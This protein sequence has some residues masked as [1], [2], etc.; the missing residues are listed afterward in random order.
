ME[1]WQRQ[2]QAVDAPA[3]AIDA[4][5]D[6]LQSVAE[7]R[8]A[9]LARRARGQPVLQGRQVEYRRVEFD[10]G[11]VELR[12][13]AAHSGTRH[14]DIYTPGAQ[15]RRGRTRVACAPV[16]DDQHPGAAHAV[17]AAAGGGGLQAEGVAE[18][19]E[20]E[21]GYALWLQ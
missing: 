10:P 1:P 17:F 18:R 20:Y 11:D 3:V 5:V 9:C 21:A 14:R 7:G 8:H 16:V 19:I 6:H 13:A 12:A 15:Q 2:R 4:P